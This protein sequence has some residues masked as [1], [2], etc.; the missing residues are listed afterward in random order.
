MFHVRTAGRA[1][2]RFCRSTL[3][4]PGAW[5]LA[6]AALTLI[7]LLARILAPAP[8]LTRS[9]HLLDRSTPPV[10]DARAVPIVEERITSLD[11]AFIE[12]HRY[13]TRFYQ[14]RWTGV[15]WSPRP[16]HIE[17]DAAADDGVTIRIDGE[18]VLERN[19]RIG[20]T[21]A[22]IGVQLDAGA[23]H[24]EIVHW[25]HGGGRNLDV[26]W[27]HA[28][29]QLRPLGPERV[30]PESPGAI[31]YG[32]TVISTSAPM[33]VLLAWA[34]CFSIPVAKRCAAR[35]RALTAG[36]L[37][38]RLGTVL[39]PALLG[40]SQLLVF[41][42]WTVHA[43]NQSE[44][45]A[46]F[47]RLA[48]LWVWL[49][50][51][52][53]G[54]LAAVG[55]LLPR[56]WYSRYVAG[57]WA[58][59]VMLWIQ[60]NLLLA[61]Y[62]LLTGTGLDLEQ[63]AWRAPLDAVLWIGVLGLAIV[64][65]AFARSV[66]PT[67]SVL[68]MVLQAS[69]L[70]LQDGTQA[71]NRPAATNST[72]RLPPAEIYELSRTRNLIH[73]VLDMFS[74]HVFADIMR[75]APSSFRSDW[76]GFTYYPDHLGAMR[77]TKGSL[78][79]ML[80][81]AAYGNRIPFGEYLAS[82]PSI[83]HALGKQGY[84]LRSL[85]TV[86]FITHPDPS[87]P[88]VESAIRYTIPNPYGGYRDYLR[89]AAARLLD[90]SLF[91]HA[92]HGM[93]DSIYRDRQ[94]LVESWVARWSD[95]QNPDEF[96]FSS[97]AFFS[98]FTERITSGQDAP[99]FTFIH[100]YHPHPP[101]VTD[102]DCAYLEGS[103]RPTRER[104][105]A[106]ARCSLKG[107]GRLLDRL[108]ALDL[109]DRSAIMVTSD[110]GWDTFRPDS[111]PLRAIDTPAGPLDRVATDATPL[112]LIKPIGAG[113]PLRTSYAPT[114]VT[115][116]PATL[117]DLVDLPNTL[118]H[119]E[120]ALSLAPDTRRE[121]TYADHQWAETWARPYF[122]L[123]HVFSVDGR[124]DD[125]DAWRFRQAVFEPSSSPATQHRENQVGLEIVE[126]P[127]AEQSGRRVYQTDDY[128]VFYVPSDARHITFDL[129]NPPPTISARTVTVRVDGRDAGRYE[130]AGDGWRTV[131]IPVEARNDDSRPFCIELLPGPPTDGATT[132][133]GDAGMLLRGDF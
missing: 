101:L 103:P 5:Y 107:V 87:L 21:G 70:L 95:G 102:A 131:D 37:R 83:F 114:A 82:R 81:G 80:T 35:Y 7:W 47:W 99:V 53:A 126:E 56:R 60:G 18:I 106:Q 110:H 93:K 27:A 52:M 68:L 130:I 90:L 26:R 116:L 1:A 77:R 32:M 24:I 3:S 61:D 20:M 88:G 31:G 41:G 91:R 9:Y 22:P 12:Q 15:W 50:V 39:F 78:P 105:V 73:V 85:T 23:H 108:R 89:N 92:P 38:T 97:V 63:H 76:A 112:L 64:F 43:T 119:G 40:P 10:V 45:L 6:A 69:F 14:V 2:V 49:L 44:F 11:L 66:A 118:G 127:A 28:G 111:H 4:R 34:A 19:P 46:S 133:A 128:A 122:D 115:D 51:P 117:L 72:W 109:Y 30:Y 84:R 48:P 123:L 132:G 86:P 17:F 120:S 96:P 121:R 79:A 55:V 57:L 124:V 65:A 42:P 100:L 16:E 36:E 125:P 29:L 59:G 54:M 74:S 13:P 113:E 71:T 8:G 58:G 75:D 62:G 129:R 98:E 104:Y 94:W 67:A 33:L 25:Q